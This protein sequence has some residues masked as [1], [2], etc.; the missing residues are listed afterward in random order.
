MS[1]C[2]KQ[3]TNAVAVTGAPRMP[4]R[5]VGR[6]DPQ[7][8]P[9]ISEAGEMGIF[10]QAGQYAAARVGNDKLKGAIARAIGDEAA[11]RPPAMLED[12]VLQFAERPYQRYRQSPR[13]T[14]CNS[15]ILGMFSP[16]IPNQ[17]VGSMV[18]EVKTRQWKRASAVTDTRAA[19]YAIAQRADNLVEHRGFNRYRAVGIGRRGCCDRQLDQ[20]PYPARSAKRYLPEFGQPTGH[21][22]PKQ[23]IDRLEVRGDLYWRAFVQ[24]FPPPRRP[25][26]GPRCAT[27]SFSTAADNYS[28]P[29]CSYTHKSL[30]Q[31]G[32][33]RALIGR[34]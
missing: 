18:V 6:S 30:E 16:L 26:H 31:G 22:L 20:R 13:K 10:A 5:A 34:R 25:A 9:G 28:A 24:I 19:D 15:R 11:L 33:S 29:G 3:L 7:R 21:C 2:S 27:A 8:R 23:I 17:S 32:D 1:Q 12:I 4:R 14:H